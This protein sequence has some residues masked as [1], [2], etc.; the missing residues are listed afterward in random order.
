VDYKTVP[1]GFQVPGDAFT[2]Y[3]ENKDLPAGFFAN[4][5]RMPEDGSAS[6]VDIDLFGGAGIRG[7]LVRGDETPVRDAIIQAYPMRLK[8]SLP[9]GFRVT[10][11]DA[12]GHFQLDALPSEYLL[13]FNHMDRAPMED[14]KTPGIPPQKITIQPD[15]YEDLGVLKIGGGEYTVI[16]RVVDP[17]GNPVAGL[18]VIPYPR[19]PTGERFPHLSLGMNLCRVETDLDG[20]FVI[21]GLYAAKIGIRVGGFDIEQGSSL[22]GK[23]LAKGT[24]DIELDLREFA[25]GRLELPES[26]VVVSHPFRLNVVVRSLDTKMGLGGYTIWIVDEEY[27]H[28]PH[29]VQ[30]AEGKPLGVFSLGGASE[31]ITW[32]CQTPREPVLVRLRDLDR[33]IVREELLMPIKEMDFEIEFV[34][35]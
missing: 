30:G 22:T 31:K 16:G 6:K 25:P 35:P 5:G 26:T 9:A 3:R 1:Y 34:V 20:V 14:L 10:R 15:T 33:K 2:S 13:Y 29:G 7:V 18:E 4:R 24:S 27:A 12:Q 21:Q 32:M 11:T 8:D 19:E 17:I 23:R 28:N